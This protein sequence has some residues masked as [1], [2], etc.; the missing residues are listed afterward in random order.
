MK[1]DKKRW[2]MMRLIVEKSKYNF[3]LTIS[4]N[5][6]YNYHKI[7]NFISY[8][9]RGE[10]ETPSYLKFTRESNYRVYVYFYLID[11]RW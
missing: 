9:S 1:D 7:I 6:L 4:N 8:L 3:L 10:L 2:E 5:N 11:M